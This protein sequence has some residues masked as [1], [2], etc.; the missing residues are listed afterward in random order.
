[1]VILYP[2]QFHLRPIDSTHD[3]FLSYAREDKERVRPIVEAIE[4]EGFTVW[5][6]ENIP[7]G[8]SWRSFLQQSLDASR[9][10]VVIWSKYSIKSAFVADE[11]DEGQRRNALF[12]IFI[13]EV[14]APLGLRRQQNIQLLNW[15]GER[16][17]T[18]QKFVKSVGAKL[19]TEAKQAIRREEKQAQKDWR[20]AK[21]LNTEDAYFEFLDAHWNSSHAKEAL[22]LARALGKQREERAIPTPKIKQ[23]DQQ[24]PIITP[25]SRFEYWN[26]RLATIQTS[27]QLT[28]P[29]QGMAVPGS[30]QALP[31][32]ETQ[33]VFYQSGAFWLMLVLFPLIG[34]G[35]A[36]LTDFI[37]TWGSGL[38]SAL[39][40]HISMNTFLLYL[41]GVVWGVVYLIHGTMEASFF[42]D[43]AFL[44]SAIW[45]PYT[46]LFD[47]GEFWGLIVALP[48]NLLLAWG[49]ALTV[50][51]FFGDVVALWAFLGFSAIQI[52]IYFILDL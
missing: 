34:F 35:G 37:A 9:I 25:A 29:P 30:E 13:D 36:W 10:V 39:E 42:D 52:I 23:G 21:A 17:E 49:L 19:G 18:W 48:I 4:K 7:P 2:Y 24:V 16:N 33:Y 3:I 32:S 51:Q 50:G 22:E 1:M 46:E 45:A 11:A 27:S 40:M 43:W 6:D 31:S 26:N 5:W 20:R 8:T 44:P 12:P 47:E 38:V 41:M 14:K 15:Q 28:T